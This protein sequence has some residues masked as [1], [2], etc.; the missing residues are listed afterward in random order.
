MISG[1][2]QLTSVIIN[3]F[4]LLSI[5]GGSIEINRLKITK[6]ELGRKLKS[7]VNDFDIA[8]IINSFWANLQ[9]VW[10][11]NSAKRTYPY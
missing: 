5:V 6:T 9:N 8:L 3:S 4:Y 1:H 7:T 2:R 11:G 10:E